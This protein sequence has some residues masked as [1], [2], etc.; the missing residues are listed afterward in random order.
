VPKRKRKIYEIHT[1]MD[2]W[3]Q[4]PP[5][6]ERDYMATIACGKCLRPRK[7]YPFQPIPQYVM[8]PPKAPYC[9][10]MNTV[11]DVV[12]E[13]L[14]ELI[15]PYLQD[16]VWGPVY[17]ERDDVVGRLKYRSYWVRPDRCIVHSRGPYARHRLCDCGVI[18][19]CNPNAKEALLAS[20]LDERLIYQT[21]TGSLLIDDELVRKLDLLTRFP[22][23][24]LWP[25]RIIDEP[26][27]G[28]V[29]PGDPGW[30]GVLVER[31]IEVPEDLQAPFAKKWSY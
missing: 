12:S 28:D 7:G 27:D 14:A 17:L 16:V 30:N 24:T 20:Y 2:D 15:E 8:K 21:T 10:V 18:L 25:Y 19:N 22:M 3:T 1:K 26:M 6:W 5:R 13:E 4:S 23:L 29:L 31:P 9:V 11:P